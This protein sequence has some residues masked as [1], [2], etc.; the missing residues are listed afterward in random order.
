M[1]GLIFTRATGPPSRV[2][3]AL[4]LHRYRESITSFGWSREEIQDTKTPL[5]CDV[6]G[7]FCFGWRYQ[8]EKLVNRYPSQGRDFLNR[9]DCMAPHHPAQEEFANNLH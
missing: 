1:L 9:L 2:R 4:R 7:V 8:H 6:N 5:N 3:S